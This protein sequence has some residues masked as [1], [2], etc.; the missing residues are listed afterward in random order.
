[1]RGSAVRGSAV[2]MP[3][4]E[5]GTVP[6]G[7]GGT[8]RSGKRSGRGTGSN[9][10]EGKN[11]FTVKEGLDVRTEGRRALE[12]KDVMLLSGRDGVVVEVVDNNL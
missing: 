9:S 8:L 1:V 12:D 7:A 4:P 5:P 11:T 6:S 2:R 10:G 3:S